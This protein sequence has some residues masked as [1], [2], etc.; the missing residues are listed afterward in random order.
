EE[1]TGSASGGAVASSLLATDGDAA[2]IVVR[3]GGS[4]GGGLA[5]SASRCLHASIACLTTACRE[6]SFTVARNSSYSSI[7]SLQRSSLAL[8]CAIA[9]R[10]FGCGSIAYAAFSSLSATS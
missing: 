9:Y 1:G 5:C 3:A 4:A 6:E 2:A 7:A 8:T 10:S